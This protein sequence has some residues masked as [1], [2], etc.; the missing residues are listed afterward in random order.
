[1]IS[2]AADP[3]MKPEEFRM[4]RDLLAA[5]L[6]FAIGNDARLS[7]ARKLKERLQLNH[8]TTYAEYVHYLRY[9]PLAQA[10]WDELV[11]LL[12]THETYF[13]REDYQLAAFEHEVLPLLRDEARQRKRL[14]IWS[15][16]CSTGEEA[17]TIAMLVDRS[18]LFRD[19]EVRVFGSDISKRCI[20]TARRAFYGPSSFRVIPE[21]VRR[22][23]FEPRAG[24]AVVIERIRSMVHFSQMN[25]LDQE[26]ARMVGRVD[27]IF[28][29]NVLIYLD[30]HARRR[31]IDVF[32]ERLLPMGV[33]FLGHSESLLNVSTAFELLHLRGDLAYRKPRGR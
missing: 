24:G 9:H 2:R 8:L 22:T 13:F 12:T 32:L 33:L 31:V 19:C 14:S 5:R 10:E 15:A 4:L 20:A 7:L 11:E 29:R 1:M 25:L 28:C 21:D 3:E 18:G 30:A 6:G 26:R 23:Y 27:A 16:G 17:Y